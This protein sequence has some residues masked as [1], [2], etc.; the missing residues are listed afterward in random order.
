[1]DMTTDA[2]TALLYDARRAEVDAAPRRFPLGTVV[3]R[4][5]GTGRNAGRGAVVR[6]IVTHH[7]R[8]GDRVLTLLPVAAGDIVI[9]RG[10][11]QDTVT[12]RYDDWEVV[13]PDERTRA[14]RVR[15]L[16]YEEPGT[17]DDGDAPEDETLAWRAVYELALLCGVD[18]LDTIDW[19]STV[20]ELVAGVADVL[21][22]ADG[23][24]S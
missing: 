9:R 7:Y 13:P 12:N 3:R 5:P 11:G 23:T 2:A 24:R 4:R 17:D 6:G 8:A 15:S 22:A 10:P 20:P 14:E 1:M 19:P 18:P 21:D 16:L